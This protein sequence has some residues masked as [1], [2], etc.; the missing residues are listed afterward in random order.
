MI[1]RTRDESGQT[2][3]VRTAG[4]P[5]PDITAPMTWRR[6]IAEGCDERIDPRD[7]NTRCPEHRRQA[8]NLERVRAIVEVNREAAARIR[9]RAAYARAIGDTADG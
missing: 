2:C 6:C 7:R 1:E 4:P 5:T 8:V 3:E 9:G